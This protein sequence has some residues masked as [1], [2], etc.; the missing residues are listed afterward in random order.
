M[1]Y[2]GCLRN[3]EIQKSPVDEDLGEMFD[4]EPCSS[5]A[6]FGTYFGQGGGYVQICE[7]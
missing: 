2:V 5:L 7:Y 1:Q 3:I 6:E 4:V